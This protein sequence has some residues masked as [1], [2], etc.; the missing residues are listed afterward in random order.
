MSDVSV[1]PHGDDFSQ[2]PRASEE[3]ETQIA[4][5]PRIS[6]QAF[7]ETEEFAGMI[8]EAAADR[9]LTRTVTKTQMGGMTAAL[10]AFRDKPTPNLLVIETSGARELLFRQLESLA[11]FCDSD[12]KLVVIGNENDIKLYRDL[13]KLGVSDYIVKPFGILTFIR[14]L[15]SLYSGEV[16]QGL[17]RT[18]GVVG[19]KGGVGASTI[20][21]NLGW[22][23][24]RSLKTQGI[25][26][27]LDLP[28]GTTALD[29]NQDPPQGVADAIYSPDRIDE[30]FI[31]RLMV[32][33][34]DRLSILSAP[35][36][37]DRLYD[38]PETAIDATID[39]LRST[40]PVIILDIPHQWMAWTRHVMTAMDELVIVT[41]PDLANL[42][43]ARNLIQTL[44]TLRRNDHP[45]HVILNTVGLPKRPEISPVEFAKT[46][47]AGPLIVSPFDAKLF[48]SATNN[49][50]M[51]EEIDPSAQIVSLL[52]S[53]GYQLMGRTPPSVVKTG[54][55]GAMLAR[56]GLKKTSLAQNA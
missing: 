41:A 32:K 54:P 52:S 37:L 42:R 3:T 33:C 18:I 11:A 12:T 24:T 28:F 31:D 45:P 47:D 46:L 44:K 55:I 6:I 10:E 17:G 49:G 35:A 23:I 27:D 56:L 40:T 14:Q 22:A 29:F 20:A 38:L 8:E 1:S 7:C 21:H 36:T 43:N 5:L 25:I 9:R 19:A 13:L 30:T 2:A 16:A 51:V 34:S 53:L 39:I 50:Q 15:S 48:G 4:P 26:V